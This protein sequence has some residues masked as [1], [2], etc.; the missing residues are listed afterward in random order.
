VDQGNI[1]FHCRSGEQ[2]ISWRDSAM[3]AATSQGKLRFPGMRPEAGKHRD[4]L[5]SREATGDLLHT[6]LI[7]SQASQLEDNQIADQ[8][9]SCLYRRVEPHRE[10]RKASVSNPGPNARIEKSWA[11]ELRKLRLDRGTQKRSRPAATS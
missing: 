11:V 10:P 2:Q 1:S 6:L 8:H 9:Q 5:E 3:I 7:R 4:R